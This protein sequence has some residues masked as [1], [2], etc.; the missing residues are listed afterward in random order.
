MSRWIAPTLAI[1]TMIIAAG[2]LT[3]CNTTAGAGQDVSSTGKAI[4]RGAD[5]VKQKL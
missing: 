5:D 3:A 1:I 4:T 2:T